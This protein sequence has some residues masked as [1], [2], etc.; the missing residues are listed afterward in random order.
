MFHYS[1]KN[2]NSQNIY[3]LKIENIRLRKTLMKFERCNLA[4]YSVMDFSKME[5]LVWDTNMWFP[6]RPAHL[7]H[8]CL[9]G[10]YTR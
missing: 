2:C 3:Q 9:I 4:R 5:A 10:I 1:Q 6:V 7:F 8:I